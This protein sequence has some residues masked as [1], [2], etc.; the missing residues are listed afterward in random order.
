MEQTQAVVE[1]HYAA[2]KGRDWDHLNVLYAPEVEY[3]DPEVSV[4]G[5]SA[6]MSRARNLEAPGGLE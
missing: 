4:T 2:L 5:D 6:V 3:E 1:R